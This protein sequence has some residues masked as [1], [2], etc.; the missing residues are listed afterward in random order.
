MTKGFSV[1]KIAAQLGI[2]ERSVFRILADGKRG[3]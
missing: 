1:S 3:Q 2:S